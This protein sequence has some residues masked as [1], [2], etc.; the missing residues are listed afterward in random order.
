[1][2]DIWLAAPTLGEL[3]SSDPGWYPEGFAGKGG[4]RGKPDDA[5]C[6]VHAENDGGP[7]VTV[8][9]DEIRARSAKVIGRHEAYLH[10]RFD[11]AAPID[12]AGECR[13]MEPKLP[14]L[15]RWRALFSR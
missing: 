13:E 5:Q 2:D 8:G 10:L 4:E 15:A 11:L 9:G 6:A 3:C 14:E 1:M 12:M 7:E